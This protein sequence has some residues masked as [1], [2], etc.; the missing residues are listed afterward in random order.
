MFL[1]ALDTSPEGFDILGAPNLNGGWACHL[2]HNL[3]QQPK[4]QS[5]KSLYCFRPSR[6]SWLWRMAWTRKHE[7]SYNLE[8]TLIWTRQN[9]SGLLQSTG[10]TWRKLFLTS[11]VWSCGLGKLKYDTTRSKGVPGCWAVTRGYRGRGPAGGLK[12]FSICGQKKSIYPYIV[13]IVTIRNPST[14]GKD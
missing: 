4:A 8:L 13:T 12:K 14:S 10:A 3:D 7:L 5:P 9:L 2:N 1:H 11:Q 6:N